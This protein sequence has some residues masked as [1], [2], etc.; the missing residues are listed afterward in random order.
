MKYEAPPSVWMPAKEAL[1]HIKKISVCPINNDEAINQLRDAIIH[2]V[3]GARLA[4]MKRVPFGSSH[5]S[6]DSGSVPSPQMWATAVI[7]SNGT[8]RFDRKRQSRPFEVIRENVSRVWHAQPPSPPT[9]RELATAR[10]IDD[11]IREAIQELWD[12]HPSKKLKAKERNEKVAT[13]L[14]HHGYSEPSGYGLARAV[15]RAMKPKPHA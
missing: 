6:F 15:Q 7:R 4:D 8:V 5:T 1:S 10:P 3:V 13:Y 12:G 14:R 9:K 2:R 11:G